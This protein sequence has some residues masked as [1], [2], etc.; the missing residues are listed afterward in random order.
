MDVPVIV[1]VIAAAGSIVVAAITALA[2]HRKSNVSRAEPPPAPNLARGPSITGNTV[3]ASGNVTIQQILG[4]T[5]E[6]NDAP[7]GVVLDTISLVARR[8]G[9]GFYRN[10]H[11]NPARTL[12]ISLT[13]PGS[14][15]VL[16]PKI[17][18][19]KLAVV[20]AVTC[21]FPNDSITAAIFGVYERQVKLDSAVPLDDILEQPV[22][23]QPRESFAV[24]LGLTCEAQ[25]CYQIQLRVYWKLPGSQRG[26]TIKSEPYMINFGQGATTWRQQVA[27]AVAQGSVI[28]VSLGRG[29]RDFAD[30]AR[31]IAG[32]GR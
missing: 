25:A 17:E 22:Q 4:A 7:S 13:N 2:A 12:T 31:S 14:E 30:F 20:P 10:T 21:S 18:L 24:R 19:V 15:L 23:L 16:V 27:Q 9:T 11:N 32:S 29:W 1:A 6:I 3:N 26:Q 5:Y 28:F 8:G